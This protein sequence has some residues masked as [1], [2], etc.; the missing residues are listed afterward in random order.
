MANEIQARPLP[1]D[2]AAWVLQE[3]FK[4][5]LLY[6]VL[7]VHRSLIDEVGQDYIKWLQSSSPSDAIEGKVILDRATAAQMV[8]DRA[9]AFNFTETQRAKLAEIIKAIDGTL[10]AFHQDLKH[11]RI[12][13]L[14][15]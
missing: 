6:Q 3:R 4:Q 2:P 9:G 5:T 7:T 8:R 13:G 1:T 12:N 14:L 15:P 10:R 11:R